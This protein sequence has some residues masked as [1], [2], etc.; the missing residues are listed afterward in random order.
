MSEFCFSNCKAYISANSAKPAY[1][2]VNLTLALRGRYKQITCVTVWTS[3]AELYWTGNFKWVLIT[4]LN[5]WHLKKIRLFPRF[6]IS[7]ASD[8]P[9]ETDLQAISSVFAM[10]NFDLKVMVQRKFWKIEKVDPKFTPFFV[11]VLPYLIVC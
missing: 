8:R 1:L 7:V 5:R 9:I 6:E 4:M 2:P 10:S 3:N 11:Y